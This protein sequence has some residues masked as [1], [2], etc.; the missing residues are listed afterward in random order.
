M[1]GFLVTAEQIIARGYS[2]EELKEA[3]TALKDTGSVGQLI[4]AG[5]TDE[6]LF[7]A[8]ELKAS[9]FAAKELKA[10]GFTAGQLWPRPPSQPPA[11]CL[12]VHVPHS[13]TCWP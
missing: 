8:E 7:T 4:V 5:F 6:L 10:A 9:G 2:A 3:L 11:A 12:V 13:P 1:Q